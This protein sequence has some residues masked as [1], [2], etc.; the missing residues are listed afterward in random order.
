MIKHKSDLDSDDRFVLSLIRLISSLVRLLECVVVE[1]NAQSFILRCEHILRATE[2]LKLVAMK[3]VQKKY[4]QGKQVLS[5]C[6]ELM[7]KR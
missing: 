4:I 6:L 7:N 3:N 5:R 1:K 2:N